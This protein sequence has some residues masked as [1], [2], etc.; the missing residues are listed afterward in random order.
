MIIVVYSSF[1]VHIVLYGSYVTVETEIKM[2]VATNIVK[3]HVYV[4]TF[5]VC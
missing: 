5:G 2:F 3:Y 4:K 1:C